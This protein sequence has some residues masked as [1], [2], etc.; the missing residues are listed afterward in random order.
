MPDIYMQK[1]AMK[2]GFVL[3]ALLM[4]FKTIEY[5]LFSYKI[6][7]DVYLGIV[8]LCF[9]GIG[10]WMGLNFHAKERA[11]EKLMPSPLPMPEASFN[12]TLLSQR[13][14][15][16]LLLI[17][18]GCSNREIAGQLFVSVNTVKTHINKIYQ[19]LEVKRRTQAVAKARALHII[20]T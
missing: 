6:T 13:E 4:C 10:T 12:G 2:Y 16:V 15:E 14:K 17:A 1:I 5:T 3:A 8:A 19:K 18:K 11:R 9:L 20:K 7:L